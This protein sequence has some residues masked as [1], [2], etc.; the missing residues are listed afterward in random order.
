MLSHVL[1]ILPLMSSLLSSFLSCISRLPPA[2]LAPAASAFSSFLKAASV[3]GRIS[4]PLSVV[5]RPSSM[6][7]PSASTPCLPKSLK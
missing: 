6:P 1:A 7:S 3:V 4:S 5:W 2:P